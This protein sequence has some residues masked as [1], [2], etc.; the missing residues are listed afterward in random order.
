MTT[1]QDEQ[2]ITQQ[3]LDAL[4][5]KLAAF[6]KGLPAK[7]QALLNLLIA[8]AAGAEPGDVQGFTLGTA[9]L[10]SPLRTSF[11]PLLNG[12]VLASGWV[13]DGDPWVKSGSLDPGRFVI[14]PAFRG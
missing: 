10:G 13:K 8:R 9:T 14:N 11:R 3:D 5:D 7:E 4:T 1:G 12:G 6:G 2:P